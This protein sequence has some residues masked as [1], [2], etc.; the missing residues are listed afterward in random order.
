VIPAR[1]ILNWDFQQYP[2]SQA[3][4][5]YLKLVMKKSIINIEEENSRLF[6]FV[7][8]LQAVKVNSCFKSE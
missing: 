7:E 1:I 5:Q 8:D 3:S 2:V 6:S 4:K